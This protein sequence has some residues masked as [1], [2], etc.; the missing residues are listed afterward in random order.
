MNSNF[1][2]CIQFEIGVRHTYSLNVTTIS[3]S[4]CNM[5]IIIR[6]NSHKRRFYGSNQIIQKAYTYTIRS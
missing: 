2:S 3:T 1:I 5:Y 6:I 4:R